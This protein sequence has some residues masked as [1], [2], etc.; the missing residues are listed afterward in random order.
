MTGMDEDRIDEIL[1]DIDEMGEW[2]GLE[3]AATKA[4]YDPG[5]TAYVDFGF[6]LGAIAA[7][8]NL[9]REEVEEV[10]KARHAEIAEENRTAWV[11][12]L[13]ARAYTPN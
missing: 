12:E 8:E 9:S 3:K 1:N 13:I 7:S 2:L 6:G 4:G 11:E 5:G 10:L